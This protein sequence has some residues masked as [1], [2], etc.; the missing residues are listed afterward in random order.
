[1]D[2]ISVTPDSGEGL[3]SGQVLDNKFCVQEMIGQGGMGTVYRVRDWDWNVDLAVKVPTL[4]LVSDWVARERFVL[5]AQTWIE[6]GVHPNIV[7][8]WFVREY[9]GRPLVFMDYVEAGSLKEWYRA[10][11]VESWAQILDLMIQ[12]CAGLGHAHEMGLVHRDVKPANLLMH[13]D[14]RLCVTD[15]GLV[16]VT[17][18]DEK[19]ARKDT[20]WRKLIQEVESRYEEDSI[21]SSLTLTGTSTLL[22]T[23]EY[24]APEQWMAAGSVNTR[25][26]IYALGIILYELCAG[27]RPFD[28]GMKRVSPALMLGEHLMTEPPDP[29]QFH[30]AIPRALA[31]L[32]LWCLVKDPLGRPSSMQ[33]LSQELQKIYQDLEGSPYPRPSPRAGAQRADALNNKAVSLWNLGFSQK[34]YEA[35][36][37]A[38]KLDGLHPETVYNRSMIQWREGQIDDQEVQQRLQQ[39]KAAYPHLGIYLGYYCLEQGWAEQAEREF[40]EALAHPQAA[41]LGAAWRALG[42]A[43][44]YQERYPE[45]LE[46]YQRALELMP[47]DRE[48]QHYREMALAQRRGGERI[49]FPRT[50][51][52]RCLERRASILAVGLSPDGRY[53]AH[54]SEDSLELWEIEGSQTVWLWRDPQ[55]GHNP[56]RLLLEENWIL[57]L[58]TPR[59]RCWDRHKGRLLLELKGRQRFFAVHS[60]SGRALVGGESLQWLELPS[61]RLLA[62]LE[63]H[64]KAVSCGAVSPDGR[65]AVSGSADRD[66][67]LWNLEQGQALAVLSGHSD[68]VETVAF[69]PDGTLVVSG[70]RDRSLRVWQVSDG[71]C[72]LVLNHSR[73]VRRVRLSGDG[74]YALVGCWGLGEAATFDAWELATG[75]KLLSG[76]GGHWLNTFRSGPWALISSRLTRPGPLQMWELSSGRLLRT[77]TEHSAD[78]TALTLSRDERWALSGSSDGNLRVWEVDWASR[79]GEFSL[80]VNRTTGHSQ[81]E[82]THQE[83]L[84]HLDRAQQALLKGEPGVAYHHLLRAREVPGYTR[85]PAALGLNAQLLQGLA[86]KGVRAVWQRRS[87]SSKG[88]VGD[89]QWL[90]DGLHALSASGKVLYLW[91][92]SSGSCLRGFTGHSDPV[93]ALD[94]SHDGLQ[95]A[96]VAGDGG[97]RIWDLQSGE[98]LWSHRFERPLVAVSLDGRGQVLAATSEQLLLCKLQESVPLFQSGQTS[99]GCL[100]LSRNGRL[101]LTGSPESSSL[102]LWKLPGGQSY[103]PWRSG[104]QQNQARGEGS[105]SALALSEDGRY[106]VVGE[107]QGWLRVFDLEDGT[108]QLGWQAHQGAVHRVALSQDGVVVFSAGAD[109]EVN[110]WELA[111][112]RRWESLAAQAGPVRALALSPDARFVL[113]AGSDQILRLWE[114]D[115][116][117]RAER[118]LVP[119]GDNSGRKSTVLEM[120][121]GLFRKRS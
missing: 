65:L 70:S 85:D 103:R 114:V 16:K 24:G 62:S 92:L 76:S 55:S 64:S 91:E 87:F 46:A 17:Q 19:A 13:D 108:C 74:R 11:R 23:P 48:A 44:M 110:C 36:R 42:D 67:R 40:R 106:A 115:W 50:Q 51:P 101:A 86:R 68:V 93:T 2:E 119:K 27:R 88:P 43:C 49:R 20:D 37:E 96:S 97:L 6:L 120:L 31:E 39:V 32:T 105:A 66:V 95:G 38:S 61:G 8:C 21:L 99:I 84:N 29:R 75:Q 34:A 83:F 82:S 100:A 4:E 121:G 33:H 26:D 118:E 79:A 102:T 18:L 12:A 60:E 111:T 28:D 80:I 57:T 78:V 5:E 47:D 116:E 117:L 90:S 73:E 14:G 94:L 35:W 112:G 30:S 56:S 15:F 59:G 63:G 109:G 77:F 52:Y 10:G 9:E 71:Q 89:V 58:E 69:S 104:N 3:L 98:C 1:V 25:A 54:W 7:Q 53:A 45:A 107:P 72:L 81:T 41:P 22:G 113:T